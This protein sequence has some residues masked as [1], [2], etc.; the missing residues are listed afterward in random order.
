MK[1]ELNLS[2]IMTVTTAVLGHS[3]RKDRYFAHLPQCVHITNHIHV[4][5]VVWCVRF[6]LSRRPDCLNIAA[7][8]AVC[9]LTRWTLL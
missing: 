5:S 4:Y 7:T 9:P 6:S 3:Q 2:K 1:S 8:A